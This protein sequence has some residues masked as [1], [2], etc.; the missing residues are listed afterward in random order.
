MKAETLREEPPT[1]LTFAARDGRLLATGSPERGRR[2]ALSDGPGRDLMNDALIRRGSTSGVTE[3]AIQA[4]VA[5]CLDDLL[6]GDWDE[7]LQ[8]AGAGLEMCD[9][10]GYQEL[11]WPLWVVS[12]VIA[13]LRGQDEQAGDLADRLAD[14]ASRRGSA[15][16]RLYALYVQSLMAQAQDDFEQAFRC[17]SELAVP[18]TFADH[19][20]LAM[21]ASVDFVDCALRTGRR[22][23]A[24]AYVTLLRTAD[25]AVLSPRMNLLTACATALAHPHE[26]DHFQRS[27]S[28][29]G[30]KDLRYDRARVQLAYAE[31]LRRSGSV[32]A[33]RGHSGEARAT[34]LE[35][36]A[37]PWQ[38]RAD[39]QLRATGT[40][41]IGAAETHAEA[42]TPQERA[43]ADLAAS[44]LTDKQIGMRLYLS[45]RTV[46]AHLRRVYDKLQ[47]SNR[48]ALRDALGADR[49]PSDP[50]ARAGGPGATGAHEVAAAG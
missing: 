44:G 20:P 7:A 24:R 9:R 43:I 38:A 40:V 4:V 36:R 45:H 1:I 46:S 41:R 18:A 27:L 19:L 6:T 21:A 29:P 26:T 25:P 3:T 14:W 28:V 8:L 12:G 13:A 39:R 16:V 2:P 11:R 23:A 50:F 48:T 49:R 15:T 22:E 32:R 35:L 10:H 47:I 33:A 37:Q 17:L 34:F 42:L 31:R 5:L 30:I